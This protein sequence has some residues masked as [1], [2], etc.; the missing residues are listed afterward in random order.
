[1]REYLPELDVPL[2]GWIPN[3]MT[4]K[5]IRKVAEWHK[6]DDLSK[7]LSKFE[8][9]YF[10]TITAKHELTQASARRVID[11]FV[12]ILERRGNGSHRGE[13]GLIFWVCEPHKHS[14]SGYHLHLIFQNS[15]DLAQLGRKTRWRF[16]LD[17]SRRAVGGK[18]WRN[19][20]GELGLWHRVQL[21]DFKGWTAADYCAKY[22]TKNLVDWGFDRFN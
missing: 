2:D 12:Q 16:I 22:V 20:K 14:S 18:P 7:F 3:S 15:A 13:P 8:W 17:S 21:L 5:E 19:Q 9:H 10:M 4:R 6:R 1:M 11:H